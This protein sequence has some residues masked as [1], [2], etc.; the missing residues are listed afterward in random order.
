MD[1]WLIVDFI[2][3]WL[4]FQEIETR[5]GNVLTIHF[6]LLEADP[7]SIAELVISNS[8]YGD[9]IQTVPIRNGSYPQSITTTSSKVYI[10]FNLIRR[11][12]CRYYKWCV[13]F[14]L[15]FSS[16]NSESN[17]FLISYKCIKIMIC[18]GRYYLLSS[19]AINIV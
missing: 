13:R 12:N 15:L 16:G 5:A 11:G 4:S 19:I 10:N 6:V 18:S 2:L 3:D 17:I 1:Q 7:G 8:R 14:L 9:I